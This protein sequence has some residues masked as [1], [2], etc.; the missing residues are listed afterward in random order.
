[1]K[2][3]RTLEYI[4]RAAGSGV[5]AKLFLMGKVYAGT[6]VAVKQ[7]LA[8]L[9]GKNMRKVSSELFG[10]KNRWSGDFFLKKQHHRKLRKSLIASEKI[11]ELDA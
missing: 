1:M 7:K 8:F 11:S 4:S 5:G 10:V 6:C 9:P 2:P 3:A